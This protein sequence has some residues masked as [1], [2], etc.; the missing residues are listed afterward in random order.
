MSK[1]CTKPTR[2][3][4]IHDQELQKVKPH[5]LSIRPQCPAIKADDLDAYDSACDELNSAKVSLMVNLSHYGSDALAEVHNPDNVDNNMINQGVQN[6]MNSSDPSPSCRPTKVEVPKEL[7]KVSMV[8]TSLKK[9]KHHLAGF[10]VVVKERTT[11]TTLTEGSWG[12]HSKLN[13]NSE[14]LYVKCNGCML[15]DNQ[16]LCVLDFINDVNARTKSKSVRK[17]GNAFPLT[18]ITTTVKVPL[19]KPTALESDTPKPVVTLVYSRKPRKSKTNV[20]ISKPKIIK[21]ISANKKE[22][23]KSWG[24]IVFDVPI[25]PYEEIQ[26]EMDQDSAHMVA[27]SKVPMLKP[28]NGA[29]LPKTAVVEGFEKVIPITAAEDKAQMLSQEDVNQKL[30]RSLSP[31]WNTHVVVWRNKAD[32]NE[33]V[34]TA[35]GVFTASTQVNAANSTNID[36]LSDAVVCPDQAEKG[37]NYVRMAYSSSSSDSEGNQKIDLQDQGVIDSGCAR[38]MTGNMSYLTDYE[39]ID[40]GINVTFGGEPQKER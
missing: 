27:A 17:I 37:P 24:F 22:P 8:N 10:D 36:N 14:L 30:L 20:S 19:R 25:F 3:W 38:H 15:S 21:S 39:E 4:E 26:K 31:E 2:K 12:E 34:N 13:E 33:A 9:L 40:G 18:R 5:R 16:D 35:H 7:P 29:T 11:A 6:S 32:T 23:I 1:Q 28:G